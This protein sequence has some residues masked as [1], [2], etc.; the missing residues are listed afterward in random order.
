VRDCRNDGYE[1][2]EA[3]SAFLCGDDYRA[4]HMLVYACAVDVAAGAAGLI[5][6]ISRYAE[7]AAKRN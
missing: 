2:D 7:Q 4:V 1:G 6:I 5:E 3:D